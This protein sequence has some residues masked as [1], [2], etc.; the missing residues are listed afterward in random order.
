MV[1]LCT[2]LLEQLTWN[3]QK[4]KDQNEKAF[5]QSEYAPQF[6]SFFPEI[7]TIQTDSNSQTQSLQSGFAASNNNFNNQ[8][9]QKKSYDDGYKWRKYGSRPV[10]GS[11]RPRSFYKCSY[12]SCPVKKRLEMNLDGQIIEIV[13]KGSHNHPKPQSIEDHNLLHRPQINYS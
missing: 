7:S 9:L 3:H 1:N 8:L 6:Q 2:G 10:K 4:P 5:V 11:E 13:Y 12:P